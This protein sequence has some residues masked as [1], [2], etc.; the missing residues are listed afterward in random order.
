MSKRFG[1]PLTF[2]Q[3]PPFPELNPS[4]AVLLFQCARELV[5]N[6][7]KHAQASRGRL[8]LCCVD[9]ALTLR[10]EDDGLGFADQPPIELNDSLSR[11]EVEVLRLLC[12]GLRTK[13]IAHRLSISTRTVETY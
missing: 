8:S 9:G 6:L 11:R 4:V 2:N 7:V 3:S 1:V 10:V 12:E 5:V 13:D